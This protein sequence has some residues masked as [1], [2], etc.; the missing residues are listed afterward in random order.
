M[1]DFAPC[2]VRKP[3]FPCERCGAW[4]CPAH[5]FYPDHRC[6]GTASTTSSTSTSA[7]LPV[8]KPA[9]AMSSQPAQSLTSLLDTGREEDDEEE[10][11]DA[12]LGSDE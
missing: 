10:A 6:P 9:A 1:C 7:V 5:S 8:H 4:F 11:G 12:S 3:L 2:T